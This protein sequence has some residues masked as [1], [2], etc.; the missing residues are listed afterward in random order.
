L[1]G[2]FALLLIEDRDFTGRTVSGEHV[3]GLFVRGGESL[4][5]S[6]HHPDPLAHVLGI[7]GGGAGDVINSEL[8]DLRHD[9]ILSL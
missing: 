3:L 6:V 1:R 9:Q 2:N 4:E 5:A 7:E 8:V